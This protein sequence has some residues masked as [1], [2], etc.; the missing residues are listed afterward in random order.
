VL[1]LVNPVG[2]GR[3]LVGRGWEAGFDEACPVNGKPLT[4]TLE[5][6]SGNV[7]AA[8]LFWESWPS[9]FLVTRTSDAPVS[10]HLR[11][12]P[13]QPTEIR[14]PAI[15]ISIMHKITRYPSANCAR[16]SAFSAKPS[17]DW[18]RPDIRSMLGARCRRWKPF[19]MA[20][21]Q[22]AR[23]GGRVALVWDLGGSGI[24]SSECPR[25]RAPIR[26]SPIPLSLS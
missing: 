26:P 21:Q 2:A 3:G 6:H 1:D 19:L 20:Q 9:L 11:E 17:L 8:A 13:N 25:D 16:R 24:G 7:G 23:L 15:R 5:Q 14:T 22:Q 18:P 4:H 12:L 10:D